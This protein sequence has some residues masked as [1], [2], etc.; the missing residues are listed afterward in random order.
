MRILGE[1]RINIVFAAYAKINIGLFV[2]EKRPDGFHD[3]LTVF[4]RVDLADTISFSPSEEIHVESD[5]PSAPGDTTNL[6]YKAAV[7]L[8]DHA[9]AR[10]GVRITLKKCIP[11][12]AGLGGGSSDAATVLLQ[13]PRFWGIGVEEAALRSI[14]LNIGSDIPYFLG[15][16]SALARG[17]GEILEYFDLPIPYTILV[18]TPAVRIA[19]RWAYSQVQPRPAEGLDLLPTILNGL[20]D[21]AILRSALRN[22]F[23][24]G[25]FTAHPE[26]AGIKNLMIT[27][28]A[29][30]ASMSGSGSSVFGFFPSAEA[31]AALG[32]S[33]R[34]RGL[35]VS[36]T[37]PSF[38]P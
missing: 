26:I 25:V 2:V 22:D 17:R 35:T 30:Y 23:E 1:P 15:R 38:R 8:R 19:T 24:A 11:V 14:A 32:E 27:H 21:P 6:C 4:H 28:G 36:L 20:R 16:G 3:L 10:T 37:S 34:T 7:A 33:F 18:C 9:G 29:V 5:S 12:G 31:A 13:L